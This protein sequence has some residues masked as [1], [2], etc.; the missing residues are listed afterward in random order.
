MILKGSFLSNTLCM[1]TGLTVVLPDGAPPSG[2]IY[3]LHGLFGSSGDWLNNTMLP[4]YAAERGVAVIM[5][6]VARS[7]YADMKY[8]LNYFSYIVDELPKIVS[9]A[10]NISSSRE[11][12]AIIGASM[13]GYGALK[14]CFARPENYK[15]CCAFSSPCL[16]IKEFLDHKRTPA[17]VEE[18]KRVYGRQL[19]T[20][21]EAIFG[22]NLEWRADCDVLDMAEKF[23]KSAFMPK[24]YISCG[25]E[26]HLCPDNKRFA[27]R[28][29]SLGFDATYDERH[30][31]HD[32]YFFDSALRRALDFC[33]PEK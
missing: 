12:T 28:I 25:T 30:G 33:F 18:L 14:S 13:G 20:D 11:T 4:V 6:E 7:F 3:L 15:Y 27:E 31:S 9:S 17:E 5:P 24:L 21:F 23:D 10:F 32:W 2:L 16:F 22:E 29:Q 26:D 19:I 8:G 1:E